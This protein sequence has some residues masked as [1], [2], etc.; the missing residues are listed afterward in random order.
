[1]ALVIMASG[2]ALAVD[3]DLEVTRWRLVKLGAVDLDQTTDAFLRF[4]GGTRIVGHGGCNRFFGTI[5]GE[6]GDLLAIIGSTRMAC[7]PPHDRIETAFFTALEAVKRYSRD[8]ENLTFYD[9]GGEQ[10]ALFHKVP[11]E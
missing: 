5:S 9:D 3:D 1:M 7:E 4:D 11:Y 8:G 10:I 2:A 6:Q